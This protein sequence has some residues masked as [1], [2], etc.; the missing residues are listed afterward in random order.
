MKDGESILVHSGLSDMGQAAIRYS[1]YHGLEV[2][3]TV[4]CE[5][6]KCE[7]K[8]IFPH[9]KGKQTDVPNPYRCLSALEM[10]I[11]PLFGSSR[12]LSANLFEKT[13]WLCKS[14]C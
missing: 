6:R 4:A 9:L 14:L 11:E 3:T 2:F 10:S 7:L 1:L 12:W 13:K 5:D 8:K